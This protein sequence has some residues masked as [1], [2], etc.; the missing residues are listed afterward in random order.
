MKTN[1]TCIGLLA[2]A[3]CTLSVSVHAANIQLGGLIEVQGAGLLVDQTFINGSYFGLITAEA[4]NQTT[5]IIDLESAESNSVAA[6]LA[7]I[8][9]AISN[10][11]GKEVKSLLLEVGISNSNSLDFSINN[12]VGITSSNNVATNE[13][14]ILITP[15]TSTEINTAGFESGRGVLLVFDIGVLN[16]ELISAEN[17][18]AIRLT[19][20]FV[21]EPSSL[22]LAAMLALVLLRRPCSDL[23]VV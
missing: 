21:P 7:T 6:N 13:R 22:G 2:W 11:S 17:D 3:A 12:G 5:V 14:E 8:F 9:F 1:I 18:L 19:A 16:A 20:I 4:D 23:A 10:D 15:S